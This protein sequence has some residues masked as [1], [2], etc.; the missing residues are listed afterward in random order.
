MSNVVNISGLEPKESP[1]GI[2]ARRRNGSGLTTDHYRRL[3][4]ELRLRP[5][6]QRAFLR[7]LLSHATATGGPTHFPVISHAVFDPVCPS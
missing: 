5:P 4:A 1:E 2:V 3:L 7:K 6:S